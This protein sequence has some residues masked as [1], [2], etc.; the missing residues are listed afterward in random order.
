MFWH[1]YGPVS[2]SHAYQT[3]S[4]ISVCLWQIY[5]TNSFKCLFKF[6]YYSVLD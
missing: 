1:H 6:K 5:V 2:E 3:V 4:F